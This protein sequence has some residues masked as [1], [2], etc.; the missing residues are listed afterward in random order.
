MAAILVALGV[1]MNHMTY[2]VWGGFWVAPVLLILSIP[3]ANRA[4]RH[5]GQAMGRLVMVAAAVKVVIAPLLRY[6]MAYS[7]YGGFSDSADYHQ[8]GVVLAP[9]FRHGI[10]QNLGQISGTRFL[11]I[12]TGQVYAF[13]GPTLFGGFMVFSWFSFI[14]CY[15]FYR[16]FRIA[17]PEGDGRRYALLVFFFPTM[18]FWPSSIGKEAFMILALGAAAVGAA[19]LFVGRFRGLVWLA[20][21]LWGAAVVRPHMALIVGAGL[22]VGAPLAVLRGGGQG[23]L[24]QRGRLAGVILIL[25]LLIAGPILIHAAEGFFHLQSLNA[26][27]AQGVLNQTTQLSTKNGSTFASPSPNNPFGFVAAVATVL[28]RPFPFEVR[29]AQSLLASLEGLSLLGLCV[30]AFRRLA[31]L[32]AEGSRRPYLIFALVYTLAFI[33]AFS[34]LGNFGILARERSQLLP[35]LFVLLC[36]PRP[37]AQRM[38]DSDNASR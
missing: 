7:L 9:L 15:L 22:L 35:V 2:R 29:N 10:Y 25:G 19:Q 33:Y 20:L 12:L 24:R 11:E 16:A 5:D 14:G 21:G 8:A 36:I 23:G 37:G 38:P 18:L 28:F 17:Y 4:A 27:T 13:I 1:G 3:I 32:P 6:W 30:L 34:A 26:E 31:R